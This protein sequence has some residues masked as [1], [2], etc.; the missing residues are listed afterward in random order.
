MSMSHF[1]RIRP[2]EPGF[3][4]LLQKLRV[5]NM[6]LEIE[7]SIYAHH[8]QLP[9]FAFLIWGCENSL[10]SHKYHPVHMVGGEQQA[11]R[12]LITG[13]YIPG[14]NT[15]PRNNA[16]IHEP[17]WESI[18]DFQ[19]SLQKTIQPAF[20]FGSLDPP[21]VTV[22]EVGPIGRIDVIPQGGVIKLQLPFRIVGEGR[23]WGRLLEQDR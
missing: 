18:S 8:V 2:S 19:P 13:L 5:G 12:R 10:S 20:F 3:Y 14:H 16:A 4:S 21:L 23:E 6:V 22:A 7:R 15:P 9:P 1:E 17:L 11:G